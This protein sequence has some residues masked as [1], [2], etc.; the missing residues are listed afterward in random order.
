MTQGMKWTLDTLSGKRFY[1][2]AT[3]REKRSGLI[4]PARESTDSFTYLDPSRVPSAL[5]NELNDEVKL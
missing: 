1:W 3:V 2:N 4:V 5:L